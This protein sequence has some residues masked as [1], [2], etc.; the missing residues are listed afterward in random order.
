MDPLAEQLQQRVLLLGRAS[1]CLT[2]EELEEARCTAILAKE[3]LQHEAFRFAK[4]ADLAPVLLLYQGDGTPQ[5]V[6]HRSVSQ[7]TEHRSVTREGGDN[8]E[9]FCQAAFVLRDGDGDGRQLQHRMVVC[10]PRAL[11]GKTS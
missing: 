7:V 8:K 1:R 2:K 9:F 11:S 6:R 5:L 4:E 10:E 3:H